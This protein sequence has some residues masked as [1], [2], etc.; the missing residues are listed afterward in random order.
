M[1]RALYI[2][3]IVALMFPPATSR[4]QNRPPPAA[5]AAAQ[6]NPAAPSDADIRK[7]IVQLG[8]DDYDAREQAVKRLREIGKPALPH[9]KAALAAT[10]DI[11]VANRARALIRRIETRP[12]PGPNLDANPF[13]NGQQ[14][15]I[16]LSVVNGDKV[17]EVSELGRDI[18][19]VEGAGGIVMT[20]TG[21]IDGQRVTEEYTA[22]SAD[23]LQADN[24]EAFALFDQW[25][26]AG[27]MGAAGGLFQPQLQLRGGALVLGP[28]A[29]PQE[30][31]LLRLRLEKQMKANR[32]PDAARDDVLAA[33]DKVTTAR[34]LGEMDAYLK[35]SDDLHTILE[36]QKLDPGELLPPPAKTRLGVSVQA[37]TRLGL[38]I[39]RVSEKSRAERLGLQPGDI[40]QKVDGK[41]VT[42]VGE[43][44]KAVGAKANG[45]VLEVRR[46]GKDVKL[47][48]KSDDAKK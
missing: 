9:L 29:A 8:S 14:N 21:W 35:L 11:E 41:A 15:A 42:D 23:E 27:M 28:R 6:D 31:D 45:L 25:A 17:T 1:R 19:I 40:I 18:K 38:M 24:P 37:E 10:A 16:R 2:L 46:E 33:L 4:A 5:A 47:E 3:A 36:K 44:R 22:R 26:G 20:V 39:G 7:L 34:D 43:L 48:E 32:T 13:A 30:L 12:V